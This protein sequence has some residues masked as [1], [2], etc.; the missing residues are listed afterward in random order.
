ML[1][2]MVSGGGWLQSPPGLLDYLPVD[3]DITF[4]TTGKFMN[5]NQHVY[6]RGLLQ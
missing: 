4:T 6:A 5:N 3:T 1:A 2:S